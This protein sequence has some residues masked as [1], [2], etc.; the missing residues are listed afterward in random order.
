MTDDLE[1]TGA[2]A[3]SPEYIVVYYDVNTNNLYNE[4]GQL[5]GNKDLS[6][7]LGNDFILEMHYV[8]GVSTSHVPEEWPVWEGLKNM[9]VSST[10]SFD[11][12]FIHAVEGHVAINAVAGSNKVRI[13]I[14]G[15]DKDTLGISGILVFN[16]FSTDPM[17]IA[18]SSYNYL[19][20]IDFEFN[21]AQSLPVSVSGGTP[22]TPV[23]VSAP[24][25]LFINSDDIYESNIPNRYDEGVFKIPMSINSRKLLRALDYSDISYIEG[26]LEHDIYVD[27]DTT[28]GIVVSGSTYTRNRGNDKVALDLSD[29]TT[30]RFDAWSN[31]STSY[32]TRGDIGNSV[33]VYSISGGTASLTGT[34]ANTVSITVPVLFRTFSFPFV[35]KNL[36][37][38]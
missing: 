10:F 27:T 2:T 34:T 20:G 18:Y 9:T 19:S 5:Y 26:E 36:V 31:G 37:D 25:Y 15:I 33:S 30:Y 6:A 21:L 4:E 24:L 7:F 28:S 14:S 16:P 22:A 3:G 17:T 1:I 8:Q 35:V 32:W 29:G 38:F 23:R 12:N 11:D 13:S